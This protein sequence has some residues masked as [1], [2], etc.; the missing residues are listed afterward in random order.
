MTPPQ[1]DRS[2]QEWLE[3]AGDGLSRAS[4]PPLSADDALIIIAAWLRS[5]H[6]SP[7]R[8]TGK[9]ISHFEVLGFDECVL[10]DRCCKPLLVLT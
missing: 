9:K 3:L 4:L 2:S 7:L 1:R 8:K 5:G 6:L 10:S